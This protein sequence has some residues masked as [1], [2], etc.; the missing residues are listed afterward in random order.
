MSSLASV[1]QPLDW[2][3]GNGM[4]QRKRLAKDPPRLPQGKSDKLWFGPHANLELLAT[5]RSW[6]VTQSSAERPRSGM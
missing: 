4:D 2:Q 3:R 5:V 6:H 1:Q